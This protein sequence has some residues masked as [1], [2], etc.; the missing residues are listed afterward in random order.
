MHFASLTS[1]PCDPF[2]SPFLIWSYNV[3]GTYNLWP[4]SYAVFSSLSFLLPLK[5]KYFFGTL[6]SSIVNLRCPL[7]RQTKFHTYIKANLIL[8][9]S[10]LKPYNISHMSSIKRRPSSSS[11]FFYWH[12]QRLEL[13]HAN[14]L[15]N[16]EVIKRC[17]VRHA[18]LP[19][20]SQ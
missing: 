8:S 10:L 13:K 12:W 11:F 5:P 4:P 15:Q 9:V 20:V 3:Q 7:L 14:K 18:V 2:T 1:I 19:F 16:S 6:F 17:C